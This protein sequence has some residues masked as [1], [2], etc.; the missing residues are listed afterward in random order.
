VSLDW[1]RI[2]SI[3]YQP[4]NSQTSVDHNDLHT[5]LAG[6]GKAQFFCFKDSNQLAGPLPAETCCFPSVPTI[7]NI[8]R[9]IAGHVYS[10]PCPT[11]VA[12]VQ[13]ILHAAHGLDVP[14]AFHLYHDLKSRIVTRVAS[15]IDHD[16][17]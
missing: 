10:A 8:T 1:N 6:H 4:L 16:V 11:K 9:K 2:V 12:I 5:L 15:G 17:R 14:R 7:P 3:N 13:L